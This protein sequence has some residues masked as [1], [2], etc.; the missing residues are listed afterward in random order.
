MPFFF[1]K[2]SNCVFLIIIPPECEEVNTIVACV[3]RVFLL[4]VCMYSA[5]GVCLCHSLHTQWHMLPSEEVLS[6]Q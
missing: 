2:Y 4:D 6:V 1:A 3:E 5:R